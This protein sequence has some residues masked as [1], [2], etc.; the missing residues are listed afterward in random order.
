MANRFYDDDD[1]KSVRRWFEGNQDSASEKMVAEFEAAFGEAVG[2]THVA[3]VANAMHGLQ[4]AL[5]ACYVGPGDEV[6]VDPIVVFG[7]LA[8]MYCNA[9]P[10]F[11]DIDPRTFNMSPESLRAKITPRTRAVI[12]TH[13][14]GL[15]CEMDEIVSVAREHN[16]VVIED[17]A[18]ALYATYKGR[19]A[20]LIGD[21]GVFSFNHRK[22]LSTG[23]GGAMTFANEKL[24]QEVRRLHFGRVPA[25]ISWNAQMPGVVAA[26]AL[27]QLPKSRRYVEDD[28]RNA[29]LM[30]QAVAGCAFIAPQSVPGHS[31]SAQHLWTADYR[32]E[33]HGIPMDDFRRA[34]QEEGA[35]YFLFGFMPANWQGIKASPAYA[36]PVFT[37]PAGCGNGCSA[38]CPRY[39]G[40]ESLR[41]RNVCENAERI[42]PRLINT[43]LSPI[44]QERVERLAEGLH[45]AVRRFS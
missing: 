20:G 18:H 32:G 9:V 19:P 39:D 30:D 29:E 45:R 1:L 5:Q 3:A 8:A 37:D 25:R 21:V 4:M 22:Q 14:G 24:Y 44:S 11:A 26:V 17:C 6:I 31:W 2:A 16:L 38:A 36:Y 41:E 7:G 27:S 34:C 28:H 10:V 23:Q 43:T 33:E 13:F 12:C 35:D 40:G 42:S 15:P